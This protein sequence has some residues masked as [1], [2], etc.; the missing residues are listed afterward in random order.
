M[1][2]KTTQ[3]N[4]IKKIIIS[5]LQQIRIHLQIAQNTE[6]PFVK[7]FSDQKKDY[8]LLVLVE[9]RAIDCALFKGEKAAKLTKSF[10]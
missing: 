5:L 1:L 10:N 7:Y 6:N 9:E 4:T 2:Q 3:Q 8:F